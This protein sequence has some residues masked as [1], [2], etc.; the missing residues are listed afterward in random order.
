MNDPT[1][2]ILLQQLIGTFPMLIV[3]LVGLG[4]AVVFI[5]KHTSPAVLT[6]LA[7]LAFWVAAGG[8]AFAQAYLFRSR[9]E[10]GWTN[11]QYSQMMSIASI[12]TSL[13]RALGMSLLLAAVFVGR[14]GK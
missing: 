7:I 14:K 2:S 8:A 13:V 9:L 4:L 3:S 6:I 1:I 10:Y 5:R 12:S 11:I